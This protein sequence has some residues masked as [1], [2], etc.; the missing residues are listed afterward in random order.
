MEVCE[1]RD[2]AGYV[3]W[4]RDYPDG[5]VV[6]ILRS[7]H[8]ADARIHEA[9][10]RHI[11]GQNPHG[12]PWTGS[13]VKV[14]ADRRPDLDEW[15]NGHVKGAVQDCGTCR[16]APQRRPP[17]ETP[18]ASA[19]HEDRCEIHGPLPGSELVQ[20]WADGYIGFRNHLR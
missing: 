8:P 9:G 1:F 19:G 6:N 14:C 12:G 7:H 10:C 5:F 11:S 18:T 20:A 2:D 16:A 17:A 3:E 15:V 13:Y 4:L